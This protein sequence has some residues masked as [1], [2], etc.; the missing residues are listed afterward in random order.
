[1]K[2]NEMNK[3]RFSTSA[4][5][6]VFCAAGVTMTG[7][8]GSDAS[9]GTLEV[10]IYGEEFIEQGIPATEFVDGWAVRFDRFLV[11]L[12]E[13]TVAKGHGAPSVSHP[14]Q[15][16]FELARPSMPPG[17]LVT[18]AMVDGG[19]YDHVSYRIKPATAAATA[20]PGIEAATAAAMIATG[21]SVRVSGTGSKA[22]KTVAFSWG[23]TGN[24]LH[25]ECHG[26]ANVDGGTAK[27]EI[28]IH[29]DHLFYDDLF[30]SEPN[31]AFELI[32]ASDT[33]ADGTVTKE[34]LAAKDITKE[35][36]YQVGSEPI[37]N[38]WDF[39]ARQVTTLGH[40]DGEGHCTT[41][42]E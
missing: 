27:T 28:T 24:V 6:I 13:V 33:N 41:K 21:E 25:S 4:F 40:I 20:G 8:C 30:A 14:A 36:R 11:S 5:S 29:G 26:T 17:T 37:K 7:A 38:L 16:I 39:I 3:R 19:D 23:F 32:A 18:S 12:S 31:L 2:E 22:G 42:I 1:V 34:E 9:P 10:R 35:A 15:Q